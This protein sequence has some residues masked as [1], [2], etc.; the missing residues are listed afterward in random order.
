LE[1]EVN[2]DE[3]SIEQPSSKRKIIPEKATDFR[4]S[5]VMF[6]AGEGFFIWRNK[7]FE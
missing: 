6:L 2:P 5:G 1:I 4:W 3:R 7:K